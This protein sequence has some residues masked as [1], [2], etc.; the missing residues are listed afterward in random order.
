MLSL[1]EQS[2]VRYGSKRQ[3]DDHSYHQDGDHHVEMRVFASLDFLLPPIAKICR[4]LAPF[5]YPVGIRDLASVMPS[6]AVGVAIR[7]A[8]PPVERSVADRRAAA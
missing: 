3:G 4:D 8:E 6:W 5:S 2:R 1:G 7:G